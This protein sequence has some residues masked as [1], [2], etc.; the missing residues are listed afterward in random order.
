MNTIPIVD[1][2]GKEPLPICRANREWLVNYYK[3]PEMIALRYFST[4][5]PVSET[6][7]AE[8][9]KAAKHL[10]DCPKC[11]A[12]IHA[13]I[14]EPVMRRQHRLTKYCCAGMFV[15]FEE[16]KERGK[17]QISFTMFRGEDPCWMIDGRN[18]FI[19]YCPWCGKKLPDRP[20][21]PDK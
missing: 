15:A 19:S 14:P 9:D 5:M 20:F 1:A 10:R 11:K 17:T 7:K 12:W 3:L 13:V 4:D 8:E 16:S 2:D 6:K 18:S 21:I